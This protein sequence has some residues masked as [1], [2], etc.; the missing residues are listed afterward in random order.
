MNSKNFDKC[1]GE[2]QRIEQSIK[3]SLVE[4]TLIYEN[5]NKYL[6]KKL[7]IMFKIAQFKSGETLIKQN[8]LPEKMFLIVSGSACV[9]IIKRKDAQQSTN[10][11]MRQKMDVFVKKE[12]LILKKDQ[13]I[14]EEFVFNTSITP[15]EVIA[16]S[17]LK[18]YFIELANLRRLCKE[19]HLISNEITRIFELKVDLMNRLVEKMEI[20]SNS[21][22]ITIQAAETNVFHIES[23]RYNSYLSS[24]NQIIDPKKMP[25]NDLIKRLRDKKDRIQFSEYLKTKEGSILSSTN[26]LKKKANNTFCKSIRDVASPEKTIIQVSEAYSMCKE[27]LDRVKEKNIG[28]K[29]PGLRRTQ[30]TRTLKEKSYRIHSDIDYRKGSEVKPI[31]RVN[32]IIWKK[33]IH[34]P[35]F[36]QRK[37]PLFKRRTG[38]VHI[39]TY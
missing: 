17:D 24:Q 28:G 39:P 23:H 26:G 18:V 15:Y 8:S 3:N 19:N 7:S 37:G 38:S 4:R 36:R 1:F 34:N 25:V 32:S 10:S 20:F 6:S 16:K 31:S 11:L 14:G 27:M 30:S 9:Q 29:V 35:T 5:D 21:K 22:L 13:I 2:I 12:I 33:S